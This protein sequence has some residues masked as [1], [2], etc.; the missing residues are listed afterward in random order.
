MALSLQKLLAIDRARAR[1]EANTSTNS[2]RSAP[3]MRACRASKALHSVKKS[4]SRDQRLLVQI[5]HHNKSTAAAKAD[6]LM[7]VPGEA[8]VEPKG[9][10]RWQQV[11][12]HTFLKIGFS[13]PASTDRA[14]NAQFNLGKCAAADIR[15]SVSSLLYNLQ[16][17]RIDVRLSDFRSEE[18]SSFVIF[19]VMWDLASF[20]VAV[21]P[22]GANTH[23]IMGAHGMLTFCI[24]NRV[25]NEEVVIPPTATW[26]ETAG[27]ML[28]VLRRHCP[29]ALPLPDRGG[30]HLTLL[31]LGCDSARSNMKLMNTISGMVPSLILKGRCRNHSIG[32]CLEP[33]C[34]FLGVLCPAFCTIQRLHSATFHN[35]FL[36][37][38]CKVIDS[39]LV[40][41]SAVKDPWYRPSPSDRKYAEMV[42]ELTYYR[43]DLHRS[44]AD[45]DE[46]SKL[47]EEDRLRRSKGQRLVDMLVGDWR[48]KTIT[49]YAH[50]QYENVGRDEAVHLV[51]E[52][53]LDVC[54]HIIP[55]PAKN[56]WLSVLPAVADLARG[57]CIHH[58]TSEVILCMAGQ[59][60]DVR[61]R[62]D[63]EGE[64]FEVGM[65]DDEF[66]QINQK[67]QNKMVRWMSDPLTLPRLLLWLSVCVTA[68]R[69]HYVLFRDAKAGLPRGGAKESS[70][71]TKEDVQKHAVFNL[72][73][74]NR[75]KARHVLY[76]MSVMLQAAH[77]HHRK[78]WGVLYLFFK[79][80]RWPEEFLR[81]AR[82]AVLVVMGNIWRRMVLEFETFPWRLAPAVDPSVPRDVQVK[83]VDEFYSSNECCLDPEFSRRLR[84]AIP[85]ASF[86]E[87]HHQS[88]IYFA[89]ARAVC[90]T[91]FVECMFAS[92]K[93]WMSKSSK[94]LRISSVASR[95]VTHAFMRM[96]KQRLEKQ[97]P[98][99][100][101]R[102]PV[103]TLISL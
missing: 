68:L 41:Y 32:L 27:S 46:K 40:M 17:Q 58:L 69:L 18:A 8:V 43:R 36:K 73:D 48:S 54:S 95:H 96:W 16:R 63:D 37:T 15:G 84:S 6:H 44:F 34:V 33:M 99:V 83:V 87:P 39:R 67:R 64:A 103:Q 45:Q 76:D 86:F 50:G 100:G 82:S 22:L 77:E 65:Q 90:S 52:A 26:D 60:V 97:P 21:P 2:S 35:R 42:L 7:K 53:Y 75:S 81:Q 89:F 59:P 19:Q 94:P 4:I 49:F 74:P 91:A 78:M 47:T 57:C 24:G 93:Q 38:L 11:L 10:G 31:S 70:T 61:E 79:D 55:V 30:R 66:Q 3:S 88:F 29:W 92:F 14:T 85:R 101:R 62:S 28:S 71:P 13:D 5:L 23:P 72:C 12:P 98:P 20:K 1:V 56:K 102:L 9:S 25:F 80:S 51:M